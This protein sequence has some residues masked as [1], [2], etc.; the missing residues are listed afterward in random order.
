MHTHLICRL[1]AFYS[2]GHLNV[3]AYTDTNR[4]GQSQTKSKTGYC[5]II[6]SNLVLWKGQGKKKEK[7]KKR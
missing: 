1:N 4:E 5:N 7:E 2:H 6:S 3:E